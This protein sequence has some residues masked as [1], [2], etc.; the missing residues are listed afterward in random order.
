MQDT[1]KPKTKPTP[2][3]PDLWRNVLVN[4]TNKNIDGLVV[5]DYAGLNASPENMVAL[6]KYIDELAAQ[7]PSGF[8]RNEAMAYWANLYNALTVRIVAE[9]YPVKSIRKI[10]SGFFPGPW[11]KKLVEVEGEKLSLDNIEHDIMRPTFKTPLVHYMVNCASIGCPDL[12]ETPWSAETLEQDLE[13]A[14]RDFINSPRGVTTD[15]GRLQVSSIYNWFQEDFGDSEAG[16][17]QH[18]QEYAD[19]EVAAKL[20]GRKNIDKFDY[21]WGINAPE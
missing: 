12:K 10:K 3:A 6:T 5:F 15:R 11:K 21:D 4:Y 7:K 16:V 9:N 2:Q 8:E 14:A 18:L 17:I 1:M 20:L 13:T 19:E